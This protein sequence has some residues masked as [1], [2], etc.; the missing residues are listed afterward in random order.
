MSKKAWII[1]AVI[2]VGLLTALVITSRNANPIVD[3]SSVKQDTILPA[4]PASGNIADEVY[5]NASSKVI[6]IEYGDLQCPA[7]GSAHPNIRKIT[8]QYKDQLAF[9]FRNFPLST[10]HPNA[11]SGAAAA[12]AAGLQGKYWDMN[13]YLYEHQS[14]W[15]D[16][17]GTAVTST[18]VSYAKTL[19]LDTAKFTTDL[20]ADNVNKK[21][22]FDQAIGNKLNINSTPTI[23]LNGVQLSSDVISDVQQNNGDQLRALINADLKKVGVTPPAGS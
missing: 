1:F 7:C 18:L 5:G 2:V 9:V 21:I 22:S 14:D 16:L 19:G 3:V 15:V 6:L 8:E 12:E 23:Y 20:A 4:T 11:R 13:N 17:T 10:I